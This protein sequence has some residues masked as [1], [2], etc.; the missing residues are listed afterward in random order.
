MINK[1]FFQKNTFFALLLLAAAFFLRFQAASNAA[2]IY[3]EENYYLA[4]K[5]IGTFPNVFD[6][7]IKGVSS[8][9]SPD[10]SWNTDREGMVKYYFFT[11]LTINLSKFLFGESMLGMRM[12]FIIFGVMGLAFIYKLIEEQLDK[13]TAL[14]AL[15][16]LTFSQLHIGLSK[17]MLHSPFHFFLVLTIYFFF[18]A[19]SNG[20]GKWMYLA[21]LAGGLGFLYYPWMLLLLPVLFVFLL[22]EKE[23][24]NWLRRKETYAACFIA[25][26]IIAPFFFWNFNGFIYKAGSDKPL[27]NIGFSLRGFYLYFA[28]FFARFSAQIRL[29]H[30]D[31]LGQKLFMHG[32][33]GM[34]LLGEIETEFP[35]MDWVLSLLIF[36]GI[37]YGLRNK[38]KALIRFSLLMFFVFFVIMSVVNGNVLFLDYSWLDV[39]LY[40]GVILCAFLFTDIQ[41]K[42]KKFFIFEAMLVVYL[43]INALHLISAPEDF[44]GLPE[45][46]LEKIYRGENHG[47]WR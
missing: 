29:L 11:L 39:T 30:W 10:E 46:E 37:F 8:I 34:I 35:V 16:I 32:P 25:F 19:L 12:L 28:D 41:K 1:A 2:L 3:D 21:G 43:M 4:A 18:K 9:R 22:Q 7:D 15:A 13:R 40:P 23:C 47:N 26:C 5:E 20:Q 42:R 45:S 27:L 38:E 33:K 17:V 14:L 44:Y 6:L 24:R 31:G 36:A